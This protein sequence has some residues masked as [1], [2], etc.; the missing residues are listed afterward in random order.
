MAF[1]EN[2]VV[3]GQLTIDDFLRAS[4]IND[5]TLDEILNELGA[6]SDIKFEKGRWCNKDC[7]CIQIKEAV[8]R[9]CI[10]GLNKIRVEYSTKTHGSSLLVRTKEDAIKILKNYKR[11][12][13]NSD[14]RK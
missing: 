3:N 2:Y 11:R 6:G 14:R 4:E 9:V 8:I 5:E 13:E 12:A 7:G 10:D 1:G